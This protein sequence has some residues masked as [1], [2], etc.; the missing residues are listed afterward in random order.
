ME[1]L[2]ISPFISTPSTTPRKNTVWEVGLG[3]F[4]PVLQRQSAIEEEALESNPRVAACFVALLLNRSVLSDSLKP[5]ELHHPKL[6][7]PSLSPWVCSNSCPLS[8]WHH[9]T[10]SS[11]VAPSSSCLQ[12]PSIR[13]FSH[14][15]ILRIR[16]PENWSFSFSTSPS[17]EYSGLI[18]FRIDWFDLLA[19]QHHSSKA[20]GDLR[21]LGLLPP[22]WSGRNT[23][24]VRLCELRKLNLK[25]L[26]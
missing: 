14:E 2:T 3:M 11:S 26:V 1:K 21:A 16:W 8:Q 7:C 6:P 4:S 25:F 24:L 20:S 23:Y 5:H 18:S 22:L 12:S 17:N 10:I 19:V 13:V 9:P 15:S